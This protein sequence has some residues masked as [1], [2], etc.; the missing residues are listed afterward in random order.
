MHVL[1]WPC[2]VYV[3][4]LDIPH[5]GFTLSVQNARYS[6]MA[7]SVSTDYLQDGSVDLSTYWDKCGSLSVQCDVTFDTTTN[8]T[9]QYANATEHIMMLKYFRPNA[10]K[11][12][13]LYSH[14]FHNRLIT[15]MTKSVLFYFLIFSLKSFRLCISQPIHVSLPV[16]FST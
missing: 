5:L 14:I 6:G 1:E 7:A 4:P 12:G 13:Q 3:N 8:S 2:G 9:C 10:N 11:T 15:A 16:I